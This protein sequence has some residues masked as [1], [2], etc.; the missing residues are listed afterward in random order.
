M[1]L[2]REYALAGTEIARAQCGTIREKLFKIG[3]QIIISVRKVWIH[4]SE[5]YPYKEL[6]LKIATNLKH[7]PSFAT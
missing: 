3:A 2:L 6:F 7:L 4:Y 5:A 1:Q